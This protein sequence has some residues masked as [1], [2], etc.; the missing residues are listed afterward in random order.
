[1][2]PT[3]GGTI[4]ATFFATY[5]ATVQAA[6]SVSTAPY[7]IIDLHNYARWNGGIIGQGGPTNNEF[8]GIWSQIAKKYASN[9]KI[10]VSALFFILHSSPGSFRPLT[11][12]VWHYERAARHALTVGLVYV[13]PVSHQR[14]PSGRCDDTIYTH[15]WLDILECRKAPH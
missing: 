14:Y 7:V 9:D 12:L 8:T 2:T 4:D 6:L 3:L 13:R 11:H 15:A 10:I 5:D 1:M